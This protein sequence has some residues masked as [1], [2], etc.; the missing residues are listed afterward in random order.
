MSQGHSQGRDK[1]IDPPRTKLIITSYSRSPDGSTV[2][3]GTFGHSL[4]SVA[5][6]RTTRIVESSLDSVDNVTFLEDEK[7]PEDNDDMTIDSTMKAIEESV[8]FSKSKVSKKYQD[9]QTFA[10][11]HQAAE[12]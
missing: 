12:R 7:A 5:R 2:E 4:D 8:Q 9:K 1:A 10:W 11:F 3:S 6:K